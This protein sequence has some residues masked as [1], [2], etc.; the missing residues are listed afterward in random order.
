[1]FSYLR[2]YVDV[3]HAACSLQEQE[4][5]ERVVLL[6]ALNHVVRTE[7]IVSRNNARIKANLDLLVIAH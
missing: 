1:M 6:H 2:E 3:F 7:Q 4:R 5:W